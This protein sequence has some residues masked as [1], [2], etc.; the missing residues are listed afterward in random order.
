MH[1]RPPYE[2]CKLH[3]YIYIYIYIVHIQILS[4]LPFLALQNIAVIVNCQSIT[5][6]SHDVTLKLLYGQ[7]SPDLYRSCLLYYS[8]VHRRLLLPFGIYLVLGI[9]S[10][11]KVHRIPKQR[12]RAW[13]PCRG[14]ARRAATSIHK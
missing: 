5:V 4:L 11:S 7:G 9:Y 12:S 1:V 2:A 14:A 3:V 13:P 6:L 8:K 10:H